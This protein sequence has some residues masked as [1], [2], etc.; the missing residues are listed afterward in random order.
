[1]ASSSSPASR[2]CHLRYAHHAAQPFTD[3]STAV[4]YDSRAS[5]ATPRSPRAAAITPTDES[6]SESS[7]CRTQALP[8]L[9]R[10]P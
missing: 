8:R 3:A 9:H 10:K 4:R 5:S 6:G 7:R 2:A 1:M